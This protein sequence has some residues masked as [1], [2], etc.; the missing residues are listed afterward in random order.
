MFP[1][2]HLVRQRTVSGH[3]GRQWSL[4]IILSKLPELRS[5]GA[6]GAVL[7]LQDAWTASDR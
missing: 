6:F 4:A 2:G 5:G 7:F 1:D 3:D